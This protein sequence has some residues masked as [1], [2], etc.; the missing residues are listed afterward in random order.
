M[1]KFTAAI[2]ILVLVTSTVSLQTP[3]RPE[4]EIAPEDILRITTSLVQTDIV[5]VDKDDHVIPD[6]KLDEFKITDNGK[7][8]DLKFIEF[9]APDSAPRVEGKLAVAGQP[10]EADAARNLSAGELRR[11]FAFVVDDLTIPFE[12]VT[13]V[14]KLLNDFVDNQMR[15]GD[16]VAIIRVIGGSGLLQQFTSDKRLLHR[17]IAQIT[18]QL[19][20]N[21]AF[22]NLTSEERVRAELTG[23]TSSVGLDDGGRSTD[24]INAA[25]SDID[26]SNEGTTRGF[27]ALATLL[28]A[29]EV[30]NYMKVLPGRKSLV[31]ISG[32][33]PL[34][35]TSQGQVTIGTG[36]G[37]APVT[38]TETRSYISNVDYL[39]RQLV[40]RATRSGVVINTLD[41][42]GLS[43]SRGV[44]RFTDP[45]NE[46]TSNLMSS[47]AAGQGRLPN[48]AQFDNLSMDTM[49]GHLGL[50]ALS[51]RTG[52]VSVINTSNF[53]EGLDRILSR[54]SYY[55]LAYAPSEPFDGKFHKLEIKVTRPGAH[56][57]SRAGY[58]ATADSPASTNQTREDAIVRAAM[59]PLARRDVDLA[60]RVQYRF[61]PDSRAQLD[62]NLVINANN[63]DFKKS[64]NGNYES[65]F[66][67]VGF[68]LNSLGKTQGGFSQTIHSTLSDKDYQRALTSGLS[69]TAHAELPAGT[70]QLRAVVR[71][72]G[73]GKLGS[74][75]QYIEVPD[76]SKKR[77][78]SSSVFL[79]AVNPQAGSK[80]D[81]LNALRQLP[82]AQDLRYAA[83]IY[84]P[85][86]ADGKSQLRSQTIISRDG[87]IIYQEPEAPITTAIQN[88]QVIKVGQLGLG[89]AQA[90]HY[91]LTLVITD[92]LADKQS[93]I[94]VRSVDFMLTD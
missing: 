23:A 11:V 94:I 43:A 2:F 53:K 60:A 10:V 61:L 67:V 41:I 36:A 17:A 13:N 64:A 29:S 31:L 58:V 1:K 38:I 52:G 91:I 89:K 15:E 33:L 4:Q 83:V 20:A 62:L 3:Q 86:L 92:P 93:R 79:Y 39:L 19:N 12:D 50:E 81:P 75:T 32:G 56:V 88:G 7:R 74:V 42:R 59:S 84:N 37:A 57:Y 68:V 48:M 65:A 54:S 90:G 26:G 35:E 28:T 87:K 70:Y 5:V 72:T 9:V 21:S 55:M 77:L 6:L 73:S 82:R 8:Q 78:T 14:R 80:P 66:D 22:N 47:G 63:L 24:S 44:S 30:T 76:L 16:L 49:S 45:G 18:P 51:S 46:A 71:D 27:R 25:N 40:D 34:S 69:Y 85:K